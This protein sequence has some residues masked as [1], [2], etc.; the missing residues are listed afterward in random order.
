MKQVRVGM[1]VVLMLLCCSLFGQAQQTGTASTSAVVPTLVSF[2]GVLTGSTGK[3]MTSIMGVTFFMYAEQEGGAPL[4]LETQ[5]V[6]PDKNGNY[7]VM[8][9]STTSQGLPASLFASGQ[10]RWLEVQAQGQEPQPRIMLLSVP[11]ALKAGDA[12]TLNGQPASSFMLAPPAPGTAGA[13][14][15]LPAST[16]TGSG[17]KDYLPVF[18]GKTTI[19]NSKVYQNSSGDI[20]I[21]TTSPAATLDVKGNVTVAALGTTLTASGGNTGLSGTGSTYGV[22]GSS[23]SGTGVYGY[24]DSSSNIGVEG[25]NASGAGWGVYGSTSSAGIGVEGDTTSGYGVYGASDTGTAVYGDSTSGDG[26]V[27]VSS[28][29]NPGNSGVYGIANGSTS[30]QTYGVLGNNTGSN[31]G[32]GV[33]GQD[34]T[35]GNR[36]GTGANFSGIGAGVWGDGGADYTTGTGNVGV[37]GSADDNAAGSFENNSDGSITL[38]AGNWNSAGNVFIASNLSTGAYCS[39]DNHGDINCTGAK[40]AV[41]P[42]DAGQRKVA[43]SAIESPKNWF[44]D[45]G[46]A[47]LSNGSAVVAIDPEYRQTVNTEIDYKVFPVPRGDCKGLYVANETPSSFEVRELNGGTSSVSFDYRI[48][49]LRKNYENIRMEDHTNDPDPRKM[50]AKKGNAGAPTRF[51]TPKLSPPQRPAALMPLPAAPGKPGQF[52]ELK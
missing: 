23:T 50:M 8:L 32:Y 22:T 51:E 10:A 2:S 47:Q 49:A 6:Q 29:T 44:E 33:Y 40:H 7:S 17:T 15:A 9:G 46:S 35:T 42:I 13:S 21:G 45:F 5:N 19:G 26:I 41:V 52:T 30:K 34:S 12:Q 31:S 1:V 11:Y 27:G 48:I 24:A 14:P 18:T 38:A 4:W 3:P 16:I 36:S 20:G 43:L 37:L 39:V 25:Y 28:G